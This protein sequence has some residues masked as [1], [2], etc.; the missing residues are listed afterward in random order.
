MGNYGLKIAKPG[1]NILTDDDKDLAFHSDYGALKIFAKG[2]L[3]FTTN[4]SGD[5][6]ASATHG[7][8]YAP[9]FFVFR[10]ATANNNLMSGGTDYPNAYF[11]IGGYDKYVKGDSLHNALHAY[12]DN[13]KIYVQAKGA[14][15]S[16]VMQFVYFLLVD[17]S[18]EFSNADGIT[19]TNDYGFKFAKA[20][21]D[22]KTAHEYQLAF[23]SAYKILQYYD[24]SK[25]TSSLTFDEIFASAVDIFVEQ[26][27]Y[28]DFIHGLGY[29]PLFLAHAQ[30]TESTFGELQKLPYSRNDSAGAPNSIISGFAD[31]TRVRLYWHRN[32]DYGK[33]PAV[34]P[35][36]TLSFK[37]Y[38]LTEDLSDA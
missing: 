25:K 19:L 18:E 37:L 10:K 29:P 34:R 36:E 27:S 28:V 23:S 7:L 4:G 35:E 3:S 8:G 6:T 21:F 17:Q 33:T 20:G 13:D 9:G 30:A 16:T 11:P 32:S 31:S 24:V 22:V 12:A 15:A 5:A 26:G 1:G 2:T 38:V 14:K